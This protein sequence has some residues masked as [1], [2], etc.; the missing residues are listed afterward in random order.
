MQTYGQFA[1]NEFSK[2]FDY[3]AFGYRRI[4]VE[5]PL[6]LAIYPKDALRLEAL[7]ADNV[8]EKMDDTTQHAI[9]DAL[10]SLNKRNTCLVINSSSS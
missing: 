7:Q 6:K 10:A 9:L 8:W 5:R 2:I 4:T 1:E 3:Q